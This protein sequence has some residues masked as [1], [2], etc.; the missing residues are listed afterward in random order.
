MQLLQMVAQLVEQAFAQVATGNPWR[1]ELPDNLQRFVQIGKREVHIWPAVRRVRAAVAP[2]SDHCRRQTP[3]R[4]N[5]R[6]RRMRQSCGTTHW[7]DSAALRAGSSPPPGDSTSGAFHN[8]ARSG[9]QCSRSSEAAADASNRRSRSPLPKFRR[10]LGNSKTERFRFT[11][12]LGGHFHIGLG[13]RYSEQS[14]ATLRHWQ[15]G[16][17]LRSGSR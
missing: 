6:W 15:S 2:G 12:D 8:H 16:T 17:L 14:P 7:S 11:N 1:I 3:L 4:G 5:C 9:R 13:S 10:T